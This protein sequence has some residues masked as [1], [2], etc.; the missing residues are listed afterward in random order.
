MYNSKNN[1]IAL[2]ILALSVVPIANAAKNAD[3]GK[4]DLTAIEN[5]LTTLE[6]QVGTIGTDVG[7]LQSD[8]G[9]LEAG[10]TT[11]ASSGLYMTTATEIALDGIAVYPEPQVLPL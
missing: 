8:V 9:A 2:A 1:K 7:N 3:G 5:R 10:I 11:R 4:I 6:S